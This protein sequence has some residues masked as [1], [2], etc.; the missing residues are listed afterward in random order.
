MAT[1]GS[2]P[3][4]LRQLFTTRTPGGLIPDFWEPENA[5]FKSENLNILG[6]RFISSKEPTIMKAC[7]WYYSKEHYSDKSFQLTLPI[8]QFKLPIA[9]TAISASHCD[10][11][12]ED[13]QWCDYMRIVTLSVNCAIMAR[14]LFDITNSKNYDVPP[15]KISRHWVCYK[16]PVY[17]NALY[18]NM[19]VRIQIFPSTWYKKFRNLLNP[20]SSLCVAL[21]N[22]VY[23]QII[24]RFVSNGQ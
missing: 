8:Q 11:H 19:F 2:S 7:K 5:A 20:S 23:Q 9:C 14:L 4:A 3:K 10:Y 6:C 16:N 15:C 13:G 24:L 18:N 21:S 17:C 12:A 1:L 22:C